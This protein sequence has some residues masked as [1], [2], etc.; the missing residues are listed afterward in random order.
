MRSRF[1]SYKE[2]HT[3]LDNFEIVNSKGLQ[4]S[5]NIARESINNLLK[6]N[7]HLKK[8]NFKTKKQVMSNIK[9]FLKKI[10][11]SKIWLAKVLGESLSIKRKEKKD[12]LLNKF[13]ILYYQ[14]QK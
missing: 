11:I 9:V 4:G 14:I 13:L 10:I 7:I 12:Y 1:G 2:Y 8:K 6:E 3:S 5:F